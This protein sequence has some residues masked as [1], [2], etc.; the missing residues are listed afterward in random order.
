V[1]DAV[2]TLALDDLLHSATG[3]QHQARCLSVIA[4]S[5]ARRCDHKFVTR[6]P[7]VF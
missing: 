7:E 1:P 5:P 2:L 3:K 4:C 6:P